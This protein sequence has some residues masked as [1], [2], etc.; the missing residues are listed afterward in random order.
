M[1]TIKNIVSCVLDQLSCGNGVTDKIQQAWEK[2]SHDKG[3]RVVSL[4]QGCL[5]VA[6]QNSMRLVR[7]NLNREIILKELQKEFPS[8]VKI[9]FKVGQS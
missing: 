4:K 5:T 8:I 6:A 9:I 2:I 1:D 3:S 7:L